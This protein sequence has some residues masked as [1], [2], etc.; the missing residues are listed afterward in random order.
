MQ[1]RVDLL[2][3]CEVLI[4]Q[5]NCHKTVISTFMKI[6]IGVC[7]ILFPS[8]IDL[9]HYLDSENHYYWSCLSNNLHHRK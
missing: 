4:M 7:I 6:I 2:L 1:G 3:L 8:L 5:R 9:E